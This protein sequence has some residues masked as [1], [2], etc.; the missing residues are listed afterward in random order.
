MHHEKYYDMV[1]C[2][3]AHQLTFEYIG[4][5]P[6]IT[7]P[8]LQWGKTGY[9]GLTI[10]RRQEGNW[11]RLSVMPSLSSDLTSGCKCPAGERPRA[12]LKPQTRANNKKVWQDTYRTDDIFKLLI[13]SHQQCETETLKQRK[14]SS[15]KAEQIMLVFLRK[16]KFDIIIKISGIFSVD[17]LT[18]QWHQLMVSV[19]QNRRFQTFLLTLNWLHITEQTTNTPELSLNCLWK[20]RNYWTA[21]NF[22][23][24]PFLQP[25]HKHEELGIIKRFVKTLTRYV[26]I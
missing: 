10:F 14:A 12:A 9:Q 20:S 1:I 5:I 2:H 3:I 4:N 8:Y 11:Y 23:G 16:S 15:G 21:F 7:Q 22:N 25:T 24:S 26:R 18:D 19:Q 13:K 6:Y 17:R